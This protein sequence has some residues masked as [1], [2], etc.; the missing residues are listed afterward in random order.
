MIDAL[1]EQVLTEAT[2]LAL[3]HV[4]ERLQ[5]TLV[6]ASDDATAAAVVKQRVH[7]FLQ[8]ALFIADDDVRRTQFHQSFQAIVTV[9][10]AAIKIVEVRRR[11]TAP[12]QQN[13]R[14]T[15]RRNDSNDNKDNPFRKV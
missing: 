8:H 4:R 12:V 9:D 2:L 11:D 6:G 3:Q 10:D 13:Q 7:R 1:A 14:P 5:R 15:L